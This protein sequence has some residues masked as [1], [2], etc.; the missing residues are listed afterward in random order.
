MARLRNLDLMLLLAALSVVGCFAGCHGGGQSAVVPTA[1]EPPP[2]G[3]SQIVL[4]GDLNGNGLPDVA[5]AIGI[6]RI[7]VGLDPANALADC[8]G[9]GNTGI[10]DAIALLRC[11]VGLDDWPVGSVSGTV[12][13]DGGTIAAKDG[14]VRLDVPAAT[15]WWDTTLTILASPECPADERLVPGTCYEFFPDGT[16]FYTPAQ[17]TISY[18]GGVLPPGAT[19]ADLAVHKVIGDAWY[20]VADSVVDADANTVTAPIGSLSTYAVAVAARGP[21]N[22]S[23]YM[24]LNVGAEWTYRH[25]D[26]YYST[27]R[28]TGTTVIEGNEVIVIEEFYGTSTTPTGEKWRWASGPDGWQIYGKTHYDGTGENYY[29]PL[30]VPNGLRVGS[31]GVQTVRSITFTWE[32]ESEGE[33]SAQFPD[34]IRVTFRYEGETESFVLGRGIGIIYEGGH[35]LQSWSL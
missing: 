3:A 25:Y 32:I 1:A 15:L 20:M 24:P 5:D 19:E 4:R 8:D 13:P 33:Y 17:L 14:G 31:R 21:I 30:T 2:V 23:E 18:G 35:T 26:G 22:V 10:A 29:P 27:R 16:R 28:A 9:D 12:G 6:L 34:T 7:V 11:V